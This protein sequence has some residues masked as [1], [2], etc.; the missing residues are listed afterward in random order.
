MIEVR[1]KSR[2]GE[3]VRYASRKEIEDRERWGS[4]LEVREVDAD[5]KEEDSP[6]PVSPPTVPDVVGIDPVLNQEE[7]QPKRRTRKAKASGESEDS[8]GEQE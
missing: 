3:W 4:V 7:N 8:S 6:V 2:P 5:P 1:F